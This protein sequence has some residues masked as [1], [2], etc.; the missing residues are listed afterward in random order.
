[1]LPWGWSWRRSQLYLDLP[2]FYYWK[3]IDLFI[4]NGD[5]PEYDATVGEENKVYARVRNIGAQELNDITVEFWYR[6]AGSALPPEETEWKRCKDADGVNCTLHIENLPAGEMNFEDVYTEADAIS[7]YLD[8][9]EITDEIDHFCLRAKII[10]EAPNHDNDYENYVQSNVHYV[11]ADPDSDADAMIAFQVGNPDQEEESLVDLK[12][13]HTL[14]KGSILRPLFDVEKLILGPREEKTVAYN[15]YVPRRAMFPLR[16]PFDGELEGS[17]Y[18]DLCGPFKGNLSDVR[19]LRKGRISA[20]IAGTVN[21]VGTITG[22]F[23]GCLDRKDGIVEGHAL[24]VFSPVEGRCR[25][26]KLIVGVKAKLSPIRVVNFIQMAGDEAIGG[27]TA[28][29]VLRKK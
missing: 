15:L 14:P 21:Q 7:W 2:M 4:D 28:R 12:I 27:I 3:S 17:I 29:L 23:K 20:M 5:G 9:A 10:C 11:L 16:P 1:M 26:R 18:G 25:W 19:Y 22:R 6:K 13:E 8:P 24:V